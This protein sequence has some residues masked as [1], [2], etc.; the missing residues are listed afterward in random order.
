MLI[1]AD[2]A[3]AGVASRRLAQIP[4]S[5]VTTTEL[6]S[7]SRVRVLADVDPVVVATESMLEQP[8]CVT[9]LAVG[10]CLSRCSM[11]HDTV[12]E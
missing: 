7:T 12:I 5:M 4:R 2:P 6:N 11:R 10:C 9:V 8:D 3:A 1:V